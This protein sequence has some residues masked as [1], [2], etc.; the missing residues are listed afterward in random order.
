MTS[1]ST[2]LQQ[3]IEQL[4]E[5][6]RA[7]VTT[8][9]DSLEQPRRQADPTPRQPGGLMGAMHTHDDFDAPLAE[10]FLLP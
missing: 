2:S 10:E 8:L 9:L 6:Q 7:Q 4:T 5:D 1:F 3:R